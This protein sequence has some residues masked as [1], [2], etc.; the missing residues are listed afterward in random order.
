MLP[1]ELV[2]T[3][4][5][6]VRPVTL[7][8]QVPRVQSS[9]LLCKSRSAQVSAHPRFGGWR[10]QALTQREP[11]MLAGPAALS[12]LPREL[13]PG[14]P[15]AS[16]AGAFSQ[17]CPALPSSLQTAREHPSGQ[18]Q[19]VRCTAVSSQCQLGLQRRADEDWERGLQL[20]LN[21]EGIWT[22]GGFWILV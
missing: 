7:G 14:S 1:Q 17:Q 16:W 2:E 6:L 15:E 21:R 4:C 5:A 18:P 22:D 19:G 13:Q 8:G 20:P 11:L 10:V 3:P 12:V 9:Q